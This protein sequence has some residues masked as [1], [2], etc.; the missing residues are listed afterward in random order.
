MGRL[1]GVAAA[2]VDAAIIGVTAGSQRACRC[3][4]SGITAAAVATKAE[5]DAAATEGE[6]ME[7]AQVNSGGRGGV[8]GRV[9]CREDGDALFV[10]SVVTRSSRNQCLNKPI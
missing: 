1:Y 3:T 2:A 9:G 5:A 7:D 10:S 6:K 4:R 8:T